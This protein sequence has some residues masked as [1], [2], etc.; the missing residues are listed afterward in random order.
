MQQKLYEVWLCMKDRF[1]WYSLDTSTCNV[2]TL[3][4]AL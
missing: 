2:C 4:S 3:M 1:M